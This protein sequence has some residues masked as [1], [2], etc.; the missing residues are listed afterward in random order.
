MFADIV[1]VLERAFGL[2]LKVV[3]DTTVFE[4][5]SEGFMLDG[6]KVTCTS[7]YKMKIN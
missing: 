4:V 3:Q 1:E 2:E 6:A 7:T 5:S